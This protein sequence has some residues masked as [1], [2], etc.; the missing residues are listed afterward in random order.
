[1]IF[2]FSTRSKAKII[3]S[4][5]TSLIVIGWYLIRYH[6]ADLPGKLPFDI[7]RLMIYFIRMSGAHFSFDN[8]F[9]IG[10]FLLI[11]LIIVFPYK[12]IWD[13]KMVPILCIFLFVVSTM[14]LAAIFRAPYSDA[15]FQ[16]SRYLIY[17]QLMIGCL[18]LFI[19]MKLNTQQSK[20]I[21]GSAIGLIMLITYNWNC[22]FGKLGFQRTKF[23]AETRKYWHPTP[24]D[25]EKICKKSCELGIYCIEDY[26]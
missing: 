2:T 16:T 4:S 14:F 18:I 7:N 21:G 24:K 12:L 9:V 19:F 10:L 3:S 1:V 23:R 13:P 20:I 11:G 25:C 17:P 8:S 5:A 6:P 26:R 15:Q 22:Q